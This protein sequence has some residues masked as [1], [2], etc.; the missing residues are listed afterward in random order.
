MDNTHETLTQVLRHSL[1]GGR[2]DFTKFDRMAPD[3]RFDDLGIDSLDM[4]D[5]FLRVQDE[6]SF[7]IKREDFSHLTSIAQVRDYIE[8]NAGATD[9]AMGSTT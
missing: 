4:V 6:F 5:F 3:S 2:Y 8:R 1:A 9:K 7:T